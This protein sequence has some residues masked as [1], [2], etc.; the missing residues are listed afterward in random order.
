MYVTHRMARNFYV[1]FLNN[2]RVRKWTE[3]VFYW[4]AQA[5]QIWSSKCTEFL[6]ITSSEFC[7]CVC[8]EMGMGYSQEHAMCLMNVT[9]IIPLQHK[10][11]LLCNIADIM[12]LTQ[13]KTV[14]YDVTIY[15]G[16]CVPTFQRICSIHH[17]S[18][19]VIIIY[20][21]TTDVSLHNYETTWQH[22]PKDSNLP[23]QLWG[24]PRFLSV[25]QW[26]PQ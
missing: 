20:S 24:F 22:I 14:C 7:P 25:L 17:L 26:M 21:D 4:E 10:T 13:K 19:S 1:H 11:R 8:R 5:P 6:H 23:W 16:R 12:A 9:H 2:T 18:K 3:S 15:S